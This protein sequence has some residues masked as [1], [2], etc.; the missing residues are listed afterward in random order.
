M[1]MSNP[2]EAIGLAARSGNF[3]LTEALCRAALRDAP[4]REDL[5]FFLA[6]SLQ[7]Q[8]KTADAI[9]AYAALTRLVPSNSTH[10]ANYGTALSEA[11]RTDE[12]EQAFAEAIRLDPRNPGP[13]LNLGLLLMRRQDF[14]AAREKLLDAV[15]A[16]PHL[17]VARIHAA[18]ACSHCQDFDR[19]Q[20]LLKPWRQWMPLNDPG[21][22]LD[23]SDTLL[24]LSEG[25]AAQELLEDLVRTTP[26]HLNARTRL[27]GMY[28]RMNRIDDAE[29]V[30]D[31]AVAAGLVVD[32]DGQRAVEHV[33]AAIAFRRKDYARAR[34]ILEQS[35]P[36]HHEDAPFYFH[37]ASIYDKL[38]EADLAMGALRTAHEIKVE[39]VRRVAPEHFEPGAPP[40]PIAVPNVTAADYAAWPSFAAPDARNS[41]IFIVGFPRS[42]TT[43]LEQ[44]LDAH[45]GLQSMDENPFFNRLADTL[46][47]HDSRILGSL[48][49]LRQFDV[50]ELRKQ[51]LLMVSEKIKRRWDAQLV[52]KNPL[53]MLWL[54]FIHRLY[55]NAKYILAIRH[56]CDVL[57][58]CYMQNF[59]ASIL[60][61]ASAT[62]ERLAHAYVGVMQV[63]LKHVDVFHPRVLVSRYED[64]VADT[65]AQ[66]KRLAEFLELED[67]SPMLR[68]DAHARDKGF[69]GTPSYSQVI[70]PVNTKGLNRW[71]K[72]R[73][74]FEKALPI[75]EPMLEQWG[76][77]ANP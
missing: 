33:R 41:P 29:R 67:A 19:A 16:D 47:R 44:M 68:F 57:L 45:P 74:Y 36:R 12:A 5:L 32:A 21:L 51:Y 14:L 1:T 70:E 76:Y 73:P 54:P 56:P 77:S 75:L 72:Y 50:D 28:E 38:G 26:R 31:E 22:Q 49:V 42:G 59:R 66:T 37:I 9:E 35:A 64:V 27:A 52:D 46:K 15:D 58:S 11:G 7:M 25:P 2:L 65:A 53:N 60:L 10:W 48:D 4:G 17:A 20:T 18:V 43:L 30:L 23:L 39:Q 34:E 61:T 62:L 40:A 6:L 13:H 3:P 63:W 24:L 71:V 8:G 69:I 55:P